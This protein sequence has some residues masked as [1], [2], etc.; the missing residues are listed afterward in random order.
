MFK[1]IK[2]VIELMYAMIVLYKGKNSQEKIKK[3]MNFARN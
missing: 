1:E 3:N 2:V